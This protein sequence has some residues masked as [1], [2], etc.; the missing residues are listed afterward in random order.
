M[1]EISRSQR[2][3][4]A[5]T[6]EQVRR[7]LSLMRSI[8]RSPFNQRQL[9]E[10]HGFKHP[11]FVVPMNSPRRVPDVYASA[12]DSEIRGQVVDHF[13]FLQ[14]LRRSQFKADLLLASGSEIPTLAPLVSPRTSSLGYPDSFSSDRASIESGGSYMRGRRG[15]SRASRR[16]SFARRRDWLE[17]RSQQ[18]EECPQD[19]IWL[20]ADLCKMAASTNTAFG[21]SLRVTSRPFTTGRCREIFPL[22]V[23]TGI[24]LKPSTWATQRWQVLRLFLNAV[25]AGLNCLYG[26]SASAPCSVSPTVAHRDVIV[27]ARDAC[28]D[29]VARLCKPTDGQW[30]RFVPVW[31]SVLGASN[32]HTSVRL[33]ATRVDNLEVAARVDVDSCLDPEMNKLLSSPVALFPGLV[34]RELLPTRGDTDSRKEYARLVAAQL[35]SGKLLLTCS[36]AAGGSSFTIGKKDSH[37][38]REVWSGS[39]L[40]KKAVRP[41]PPRHLASP[42]ALSFM[43]C[44]AHEPLRVSKR[45]ARCWFDQLRL[46]P[47]L[48]RWMCKPSLSPDGLRHLGG[49][50][51]AEQETC[52][53][54]SEKWRRGRLWPAHAVWPMGFA[55]SSSVAQEKLL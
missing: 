24:E 27:R 29:F 45:D 30:E 25:L 26:I 1:V 48:Q 5:A 13:A 7:H 38:L 28:V 16:A 15:R 47:A 11:C 36:P 35:R 39:D 19:R 34:E 21:R 55:L 51:F 49:M 2:R 44:T 6:L 54:P 17:W 20:I 18:H 3:T 12:L 23:I 50:T 10:V 33:D 43:C 4:H 32:K 46:P 40:S 31:A 41:P 22:Q 53:M 14:S 52:M 8:R 42:T 37:K 9:L